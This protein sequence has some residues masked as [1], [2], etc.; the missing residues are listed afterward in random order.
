MNVQS[1]QIVYEAHVETSDMAAIEFVKVRNQLL[2]SMVSVRT[3]ILANMTCVIFIFFVNY[4][5]CLDMLHP[6][7]MSEPF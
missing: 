1:I 2:Y 6:V 7:Q 5:H 4:I 3:N